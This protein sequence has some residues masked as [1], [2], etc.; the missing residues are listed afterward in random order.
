MDNSNVIGITLILLLIVV[1]L[2]FLMPAQEIKNGSTYPSVNSR[3]KITNKSGSTLEF[4][5]TYDASGN[6]IQLNESVPDQGSFVL[7]VYSNKQVE[8]YMNSYM[9]AI[10]NVN[11][12]VL[13]EN[14]FIF[15]WGD[16]T[17]LYSIVPT[18]E[19]VSAYTVYD[20]GDAFGYCGVEAQME[21]IE[22]THVVREGN[23]WPV[24]PILIRNSTENTMYL[25]VLLCDKDSSILYGND[26]ELSGYDYEY[27][28]NNTLSV[29]ISYVPEGGFVYII[30]EN[31]NCLTSMS[32]VKNNG[33][34][35][36]YYFMGQTVDTPRSFQILQYNGSSMPAANT[37]VMTLQQGFKPNPS[38]FKKNSFTKKSL[39]K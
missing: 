35:Y 38:K 4:I 12:K 23:L 11:G 17:P 7:N 18:S 8:L 21:Q 3:I 9:G 28:W 20:Q 32:I 10:I 39:K 6:P 5:G 36:Y 13:L 24:D 37:H 14:L 26:Y 27:S 1:A 25:V 33:K 2:I 19:A 29:D 22:N 15:G 34:L 30:A 16:D 31:Y